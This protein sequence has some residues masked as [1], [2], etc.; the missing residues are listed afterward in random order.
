MSRLSLALLGTPEVRHAGRLVKFRTRKE[1]ALLSY[2]AVEGGMHSREQLT[3]LFWAESDEANGRTTLRRLLAYLRETLADPAGPSHLRIEREAL[4]VNATSDMD[5]DLHALAHAAT[6]T[7]EVS[8][9]QHGVSDEQ[10]R[11]RSLLAPLQHA[12]SLYRGPFLQGFSLKDAPDFDDWMRL[13]RELW[14]R[15]V[16]LVFERLTSVHWQRKECSEVVE[17]AS[18]WIAHDPLNETAHQYVIEGYL[19]TGDRT[20]ALR[21]YESYRRKLAE[22]LSLQPPAGIEALVASIRTERLRQVPPTV[23]PLP[24][25]ASLIT[26]H[27]WQRDPTVARVIQSPLIGRMREYACLIDA[28]RAAAGGRTQVVIV[29]GEAG[30][31]KTRLATA[32]LGWG[33]EQGADVLAGRAFEAGGRLPYQPLIDALRP[34]IESENAPD[35]L[36]SDPWLAE[37]SRL[38][39]ELC[40]RYP[41]LPLP[42]EDEPS[43]RLRLFEG[44]TRLVQALAARAPVVLFLDDL[45]WADEASLDLLHYAVRRWKESRT[46]LLLCVCLRLETLQATSPTARWLMSRAEGVEMTQLT[47]EAFTLEGTLHLLRT[48][49]TSSVGALAP[50]LF[51]E[52]RGQPFYLL[53]TL[54]ALLERGLLTSR[55]RA[56]GNWLLDYDAATASGTRLR[57]FLPPGVRELIRSRL[58]SLTPSAFA[59]LVAG[60]VLGRHFTFEQ[61]C[62]V[63]GLHENAGLAVLEKVLAK[64]LLSESAAPAGDLFARPKETYFFTHDKIRDVVYTEVGEARRRLFHRR[65]LDSLRAAG[66]PAAELAHHALAARLPEQ[67]FHFSLAAGED[68]MHLF[69]VRDAIAHYEQARNL[70][71]Q[72]HAS[73]NAPN[74]PAAKAMQQL[75]SQLGRAY[76][77]L[78]DFAQAHAVYQEMLAFAQA[79]KMPEMECAALNR[80]ATLTMLESF[81]L[82]WATA[83]LHQ[84]LQVAETNHDSIGQAETEWNLAHLNLYHTDLS[85]T[86]AHGKRALELARQLERPE[87]IARCLNVTA[88]G[89]RDAG[90]WEESTVYAQEALALYRQLGNRAMEVDCLCVLAGFGICTGQIPMAID[91]AQQAQKLA[92]EAENPWG[93]A[94]AVCHLAL[95]SLEM[96]VYGEALAFARQGVSIAHTHSILFWKGGS[97]SL[98]GR[99]YRAMLALDEARAVHLEVLALLETIKAEPLKRV[100]AAELCADCAL[101]GAWE[102]AYAY[103]LQSLEPQAPVFSF[104]RLD[105]WYETE[106]LVRAGETERAAEY[107]RR[108]GE[109][110]G[111][112]RRYRIPYL[113]AVAVIAEHRGEFDQA[114]RHLQEAAGLAEEIGLPGEL[115]LIQTAVGKLYLKQGETEQAM[116]AFGQAAAL[117]RKLA[118]TLGDEERRAIFL[119]SPLV[120]WVLEQHPLGP[121]A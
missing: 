60:A 2:L 5:L 107:V 120:R 16:S 100:T 87:L 51:S 80:L 9:A 76:E 71:S 62:Q 74:G 54:K 88:Y 3:T 108:F 70:A 117:V 115:W 103:A 109:S 30:I 56:D 121:V 20:T 104:M 78:S 11:P 45:H 28:Y 18:R 72:W 53:E 73:Q 113:R 91:A 90:Y 67:A 94:N 86:I 114:T 37:L 1:L 59:L 69:A 84:A 58:D 50:W 119:A 4:G 27:G 79:V 21:T 57:T 40:D 42:T 47:V 32:F 75:S 34:R 97:L 12:V 22:E 49:G 110:I 81:D 17:L 111:T 106:A 63:A 10:G 39:P 116:R 36:L 93:K 92:V 66:A 101:A 52:T 99:V 23:Q 13:Q 33:A 85:T 68:A 98:L 29:Q 43:A 96:G 48:L 55:R 41:D 31:G 46:P 77:F 65:A 105:R 95:A 25:T 38:L 26:A 8:T 6:L 24:G 102:E 82:D 64:R 19:A 61:G 35:D 83:F 15:R 112:S 118:E 89:T 44:V 14:H 7:P